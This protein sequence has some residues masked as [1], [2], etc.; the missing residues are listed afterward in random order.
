[1][2]CP[3][4]FLAIKRIYF[5]QRASLG[6]SMQQRSSLTTFEQQWSGVMRTIL[7]PDLME[8]GP[9]PEELPDALVAT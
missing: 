6:L 5:L 4:I 3:V 1:M 8:L 2:I 7:V 9:L